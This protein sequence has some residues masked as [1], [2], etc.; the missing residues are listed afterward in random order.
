MTAAIT[1]EGIALYKREKPQ[2]DIDLVAEVR[3]ML[4]NEKVAVF[5]ESDHIKEASNKHSTVQRF[6][7]N[8]YWTQELSKAPCS[9]VNV[10]YNLIN[11]GDINTWLDLFKKYVLP[12]IMKHD[13]P[14]T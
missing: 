3:N 14:V 2:D 10:R 4:P 7:L 1:Q 11:D 5:N 8:R 12:F 13:L 9:S 6:L